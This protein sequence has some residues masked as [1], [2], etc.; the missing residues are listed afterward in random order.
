[1]TQ[2]V[3]LSISWPFSTPY[4]DKMFS[5]SSLAINSQVFQ[6]PWLEVSPLYVIFDISGVLLATCF[7]VIQNNFL[8]WHQRIP[9]CTFIMRL[10]LK[11][12]FKR[13]I[14]QFILYFWAIFQHHNISNYLN[15]TWCET[16]IAIDLFRILGQECCMQ[17]IHFLSA[18]HVFH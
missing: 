1:M 10:E 16:K 15:K 18:N 14:M 11:E 9:F 8:T 12:L 5:I 13:C 2:D 4:F 3:E 7:E 6:S 17:C